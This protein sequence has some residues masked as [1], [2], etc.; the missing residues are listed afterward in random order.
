MPIYVYRFVLSI[1][2]LYISENGQEYYPG[3]QGYNDF[4]PGQ[5]GGPG[6]M[7]FLP[8]SSQGTPPLNLDQQMHHSG[9]HDKSGFLKY[10]KKI[11]RNTFLQIRTL[12]QN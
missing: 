3:Y 8:P 1:F 9:K 11:L 10:K 12:E 7:N 4:F 5:D 6:N 2:I